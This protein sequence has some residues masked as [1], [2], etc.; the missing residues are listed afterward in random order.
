MSLPF[1]FATDSLTDLVG[2]LLEVLG[3]A[4][5]TIVS[6]TAL[7]D[8]SDLASAEVPYKKKEKV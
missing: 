6:E 1:G 7:L 3:W 4:F 2:F 5:S 8:D